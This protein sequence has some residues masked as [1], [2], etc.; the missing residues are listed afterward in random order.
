MKQLSKKDWLSAGFDIL[1]TDGFT[2]VTIENLCGALGVTKG[3]FYHHFENIGAYTVALMDFW[4][5]ENTLK[6]IQDVERSESGKDT[7]MLEMVAILRHK[8]ELHIRAWGFSNPYVREVVAKADE[9]RLAYLTELMLRMGRDYQTS[10]EQAM[11]NIAIMIGIQH[12]APDMPADEWNRLQHTYGIS[13][14][15]N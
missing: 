12:I 5:E 2:K 3:S 13:K 11:L 4:L 9:L 10:R 6:V 7:A 15:T 8:L 14:R 1:E